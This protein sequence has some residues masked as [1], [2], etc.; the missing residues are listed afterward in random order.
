MAA[1]IP[2]SGSCL[3]VYGPHV[4]ID[5]SGKVGTV[6]RR[7]RVNGGH[8]CGSAVAAS[9]YVTAVLDGAAEAPFPSDPLDAQQAFVSKMLLGKGQR[10]MKAEDKMAELPLA[11]FEAHDDFI[12]DIISKGCGNVPKNVNIAVLGGVQINTPDG[13]SDYFLPL[14]FEVRNNK[15]SVVAD[16]LW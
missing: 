6:D 16:L 14:R 12:L 7:G 11:L 3:I 1:H 13:M 15:G 4:G 2:D 9:N 5:S 8:C 10:L